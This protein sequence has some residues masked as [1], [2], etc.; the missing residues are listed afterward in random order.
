MIFQAWIQTQYNYG[1]STMVISL[2]LSIILLPQLKQTKGQKLMKLYFH[3]QSHSLS[4]WQITVCSAVI[5]S[6]FLWCYFYIWYTDYIT[7]LTVI[8]DFLIGW[9]EWFVLTIPYFRL[10]PAAAA[11]SNPY[12][13]QMYAAAAAAQN[14]YAGL[15]GTGLISLAQNPMAAGQQAAGTTGNPLLDAYS[16]YAALAAQGVYTTSASAT[17]ASYTSPLDT[18]QAASKF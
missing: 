17:G 8:Q 15:Q 5:F 7:N 12:L 10:A 14:P 6:L 18:V 3:S 11:A 13:Q 1:R 4:Y 2:R 9:L 16:Q